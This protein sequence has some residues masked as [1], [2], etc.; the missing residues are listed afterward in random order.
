LQEAKQDLI[1]KHNWSG[2]DIINSIK[3][4]QK[5][6]IFSSLNKVDIIIWMKGI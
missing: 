1:L 6:L 4:N 5:M 2:D 3:I